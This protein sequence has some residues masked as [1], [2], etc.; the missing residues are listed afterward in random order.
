MS[1]HRHRL[2]RLDAQ[3]RERPSGAQQNKTGILIL[4]EEPD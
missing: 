3:I 2:M 4:R 1:A